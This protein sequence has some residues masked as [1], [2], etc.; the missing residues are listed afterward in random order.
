MLNQL[1]RI[2][3]YWLILI[4]CQ[5]KCLTFLFYSTCLQPFWTISEWMSCPLLYNYFCNNHELHFKKFLKSR[6][7]ILKKLWFLLFLFLQVSTEKKTIIKTLVNSN[8]SI[9]IFYRGTDP[10]SQ[11]SMLSLNASI[12]QSF[13]RFAIITFHMF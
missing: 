10:T 2:I 11:I 12:C 1:F 4:F 5:L 6:K 13:V 8:Y 9:I 7:R 3:Y